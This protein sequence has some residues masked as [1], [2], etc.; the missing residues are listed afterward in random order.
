[1]LLDIGAD[2]PHRLAQERLDWPKLDAIWV[3]HFH[4]DHIGGL[5]P[6]LF[7]TKWAPQTRDR[8]KPLRI[9]GARGLKRLIS[10]IDESNIYGLLKQPFPVEVIEVEPDEDFEVLKGL[11]AK[12]FSTPHTEESLAIRLTDKRGISLVYTSDTG[13]SEDLGDFAKGTNI[14]LME[15]SFRKNKGIETH[16]EL[17]DAMLI[18]QAGEPEKLILTHL[19]YEWDGIDIVEEAKVFWTGEV[20]AASDGLRIEF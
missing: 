4:L 5:A 8:L 16:L 1:M 10:A 19:Y 2:A 3:S 14:L 20:I 13:Y 12:T 18:A 6:F 15:C 7:G 11:N 9:F 17:T